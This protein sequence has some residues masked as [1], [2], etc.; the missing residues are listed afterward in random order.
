LRH[1]YQYRK[2]DLKTPR[3]LIPWNDFEHNFKGIYQPILKDI[4]K[5]S[6]PFSLHL[7]LKGIDIPQNR[8]DIIRSI[9]E[10]CS[11]GP[12]VFLKCTDLGERIDRI[13]LSEIH[14]RFRPIFRN[15]N[16]YPGL[17]IA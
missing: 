5:R 2:E 13:Q 10:V 11:I 12:D 16:N 15:M 7:F 9:A 14:A 8:R 1:P 4:T 6:V 3:Y 17:L